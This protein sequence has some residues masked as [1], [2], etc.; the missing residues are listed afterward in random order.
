M[1]AS[2]EAGVKQPYEL[3]EKVLLPGIL[4][5]KV[6]CK[7]KAME[8]KAS[9]ATS[10]SV[11]VMTPHLAWLR[12]LFVNVYF[13]GNPQSAAGSWVLVDADGTDE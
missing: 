9:R 1:K 2:H 8:S 10:S 7:G 13:V 11:Q 3:L 4:S 5:A 6:A 12:F